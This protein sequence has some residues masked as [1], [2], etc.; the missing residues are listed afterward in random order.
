MV[1]N[2]S[3]S[4]NKKNSMDYTL[5]LNFQGNYVKNS[6]QTKFLGLIIDDSL[7]WKAHVD[8]IMSKLNTACFAILMIQPIM[9]TEWFI[10]HMYIQ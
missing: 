6:L 2:K 10:L 8:H 1:K 9:P 3:F 4:F 5:K 7:S